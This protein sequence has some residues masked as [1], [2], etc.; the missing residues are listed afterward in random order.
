M[1]TFGTVALIVAVGLLGP[2]LALLPMRAA[3]PIVIGEIAA[4]IVVGKTGTGTIDPSQPTVA[5]LAAIGFALLM[6]IVGTNLPVRDHRLRSAVP[7]GAL[8]SVLTVTI[9]A[10][11]GPL[12]AAASGFHRPAVIAVVV[13]STSAAIVLPI[14]EGLQETSA[15]LT[16][17]AWVSILDVSTVLAVPLVL[18]TGTVTKAI[19][20]S[21][22]VIVVAAFIGLLARR[23]APFPAVTKLRDRSHEQD[24]ALDLRLSLLALFTLAWIAQRFNTSVLI[25]GFA[26]G[27]VVALLGEPRRVAQQLIGLGEGFFVP[28]FFVVLGAELDL[29]SLVH[30]GRDLL[31]FGL[32][33]IATGAVPIAVALIVRLRLDDG[34]F[35]GA[36]MGVPAAVASVG[37]ANQELHPGQA[38]AIIGAAAL[39]LIYAA[40][41]GVRVGAKPR[42]R[43][44]RRSTT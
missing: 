7:R 4:G 39:S 17:I 12:I 10:G 37:L 34:L 22:L 5:F 21:I 28:L 1:I 15:L 42:V 30:S 3:P 25:A 27:V 14:V 20:G 13:A 33:A 38:T 16:T 26:A 18:A 32:L 44:R 40:V 36:T 2:L 8:A 41:A 11:V 6:F 35:A 24:W 31:L 29:R 19:I 43:R 23:L 9:A